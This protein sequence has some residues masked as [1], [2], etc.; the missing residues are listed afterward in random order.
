[1]QGHFKDAFIRKSRIKAD[2]DNIKLTAFLHE[3][4]F[5]KV[6]NYNYKQIVTAHCVTLKQTENRACFS[7][8]GE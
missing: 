5:R 4:N 2:Q 8:L 7:I 1:M 6:H 3:A